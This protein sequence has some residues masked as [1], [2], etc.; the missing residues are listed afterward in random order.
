[1]I[2]VT[3]AKRREGADKSGGKQRRQGKDG[4]DLI[5]FI[6]SWKQQRKAFWSLEARKA[7]LAQPLPLKIQENSFHLK[8]SNNIGLWS[9]LVHSYFEEKMEQRSE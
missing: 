2:I 6:T 3:R 4:M 9:N 7:L 5:L 8:M 1:M